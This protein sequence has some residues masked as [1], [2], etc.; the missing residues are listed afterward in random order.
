MKGTQRENDG[1]EL[2]NISSSPP[3]SS[4]KLEIY[5]VSTSPYVASHSLPSF[6]CLL[7]L[8]RRRRRRLCM[9]S[10]LGTLE[11]SEQ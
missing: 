2:I 3:P 10:S 7:T 5:E 11:A 4:A 8:R 9:M 6:C 1:Y